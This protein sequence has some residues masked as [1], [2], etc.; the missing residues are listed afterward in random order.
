MSATVRMMFGMSSSAAHRLDCYGR[1]RSIFSRLVY[2]LSIIG[3]K[4]QV[5]PKHA[6]DGRIVDV[7]WEREDKR[8]TLSGRDYASYAAISRKACNRHPCLPRTWG[9]AIQR[10]ASPASSSGQPSRP[11]WASRRTPTCCGMPAAT[12]SPTMV[13]TR[14]RSRRISGIAT[15][16]IRRAIRPWRRS[17]LRNFSAIDETVPM[18]ASR[19]EP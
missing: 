1:L 6:P 13:T 7:R 16:R 14:A 8:I 2:P 10:P 19:G 4:H 3:R 15:F 18:D 9:A 12:S 17:G 5:W 11:I